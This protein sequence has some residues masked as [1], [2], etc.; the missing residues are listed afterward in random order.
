MSSEGFFHID[1]KS[2]Q[3]FE[4]SLLIFKTKQMAVSLIK[5][6]KPTAK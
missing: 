3:K 1:E 5:M 2:K 4:D 6:I